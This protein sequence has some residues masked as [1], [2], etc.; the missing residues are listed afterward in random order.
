MNA[1][2]SLHCTPTDLATFMC[3]V[4]QP[5][6]ENSFHLRPDLTREM[7]VPQVKVNDSAPWH[8]DWPKPEI[9]LNDLVGWGLGWGIQ[10]TA[11]GPS[12]W[13]WGDNGYHRAFAVGF[14]E[15]GLGIVIM[16]NG[17]NGQQV[18]KGI[19]C[20][21]MG[22]DHPGLDWLEQMYAG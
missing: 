11:T 16:T 21:V 12:F 2:A 6:V 19:L 4:M 18:I 13:H 9:K 7:L 10:R 1:A 17:K 15:E 8:E 20:K 22:G 5:S 3:A 14:Q